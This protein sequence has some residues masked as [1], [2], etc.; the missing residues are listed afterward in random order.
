[1]LLYAFA[2]LAGLATVFSPCVLPVLPAILSAG[3]GR[4][5][6]RPLGVILGLILSFCFF[7]LALTYLVKSFGISAD[8]LRYAAIG[9]IGCLV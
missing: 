9:I 3:V 2:F 8:I 7:T 5:R 4:G 6:L 1:M